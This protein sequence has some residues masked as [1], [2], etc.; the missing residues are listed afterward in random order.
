MIRKPLFAIAGVGV[1]Y[2][3]EVDGNTQLLQ[4]WRHPTAPRTT[5][6][7]RKHIVQAPNKGCC[8]CMQR[9]VER[10]EKLLAPCLVRCSAN[11]LGQVLSLWTRC[12]STRHVGTRHIVAAQDTLVQDTLAHGTLWQHKTRWHK[13]R[14]GGTHLVGHRGLEGCGTGRRGC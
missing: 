7:Q 4:S 14:C 10:L 6:K 8:L 11:L 9:V 1:M 13:T 3:F 5:P 12:G 2:V